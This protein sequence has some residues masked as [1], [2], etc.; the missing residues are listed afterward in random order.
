[1]SAAMRLAFDAT[2]PTGKSN[3]ARASRNPG[4][5]GT[6]PQSSNRSRW[7]ADGGRSWFCGNP[8]RFHAL[9]ELFRDRLHEP[10]IQVLRVAE[11]EATVGEG[12]ADAVR[13]HGIVHRKDAG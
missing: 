2:A 7:T 3:W 4:M 5:V 6:C 12:A 1:M 13:T 10:G 11:H 9:D 8:A